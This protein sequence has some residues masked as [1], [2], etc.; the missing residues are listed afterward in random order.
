MNVRGGTGGGARTTRG[1]MV[2]GSRVGIARGVIA[3][4]VPGLTLRMRRSS[5]R[6]GLTSMGA[7]GRRIRW[8]ISWRA[9]CSLCLVGS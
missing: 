7:R 8:R 4:R 1:P 2:R 3:M 6:R 9:C 5:F